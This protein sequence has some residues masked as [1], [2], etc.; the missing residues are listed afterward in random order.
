M[1]HIKVGQATKTPGFD[2][3]GLVAKVEDLGLRS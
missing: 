1:V 3:R 2:T